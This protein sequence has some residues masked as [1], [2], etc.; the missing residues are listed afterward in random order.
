VTDAVE[1][2]WYDS[3]WLR[4]YVRAKAIIREV[5]PTV[6]E[7]FEAAMAVFQAPRDFRVKQ[8]S[9]LLTPDQME[10]ARK[11]IAELDPTEIERHELM[12]FG[13]L[14]VHDHPVFTQLQRTFTPLVSELAGEDLEPSYNFLS[15]YNN[16]GVCMPHMDA[17]QA[18]WTLDI[19]LDQ[20][21]PWP[22]SFSQ[23]V[24]WPEEFQGSQVDWRTQILEDPNLEFSTYAPQVNDALF[25]TGSNQWHYR[26]RIAR[27][28]A[29]NFCHLMFLHYIPAGSSELVNPTKWSEIFGIPELAGLEV[30]A[31]RIRK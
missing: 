1:F 26:D 6:L 12:L 22:I 31:S 3:P 18:K 29:E 16:L 21:E 10:A 8:I 4:S 19:C 25:F 15:L 28:K 30:A 23:P 9:S 5:R 11:I 27:T 24:S 7:D 2:P 13:R 17:P 20:S 14:V